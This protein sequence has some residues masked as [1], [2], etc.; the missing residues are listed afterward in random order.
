MGLTSNC[1]SAV[2]AALLQLDFLSYLTYYAPKKTLFVGELNTCS[3][4]T[5][6]LCL[7]TIDSSLWR[8]LCLQLME[9]SLDFL[10]SLL[11]GWRT[12]MS[13]VQANRALS[14]CKHDVLSSIKRLVSVKHIDLAVWRLTP[15]VCLLVGPILQNKTWVRNVFALATLGH[16]MVNKRPT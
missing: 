10:S 11:A 5:S 14:H 6:K 4:L 9:M 12:T 15:E 1:I 7:L 8:C 13:S 3:S 16:A 2:A